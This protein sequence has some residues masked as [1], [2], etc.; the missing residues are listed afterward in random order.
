MVSAKTMEVPGKILLHGIFHDITEIRKVQNALV[1]SEARYR[2]LV[3]LAQVGIWAINNEFSSTVFVN[4]RISEM[5]GYSESEMMRKSLFDFLDEE[6]K[7]KRLGKIIEDISMVGL[8]KG[9][10]E[11]E[12]PCKDGTQINTSH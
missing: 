3:E 9:Q 10:Y 6:A 7:F 4:R 5:L 8:V 1:E 2:Q 12:F 11:Y